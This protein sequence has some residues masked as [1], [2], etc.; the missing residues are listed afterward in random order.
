MRRGPHPV[1]F[2]RSGACC[3][4]VALACAGGCKSDLNHQLLERELRY[5]EDQIYRLQDELQAACA[6]LERTAGENASLKRQLGVHDGDS[7]A[8]RT[9]PVRPR[10]GAPAPVTVPPALEVPD[11]PAPPAAPLVPPTLEGVPPLPAGTPETPRTSALPPAGDDD[12]LELPAPPDP[13][14]VRRLSHEELAVDAGRVTHLVVNAAQ[15]SCLDTD[16]DGT[17][18]GLAVVFE[19]RDADERLVAVAGPV[20]IAVFDAA[21]GA[22]P[23]TGEAAPIARWDIAAEESLTRFRRTSRQRGLAF[24][25]PWPGRP[26]AGGHVRVAV[27]MSPPDAEPLEADATVAVR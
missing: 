2:A 15:T 26:P 11:T 23:S 4:L 20:S 27:R 19:P 13:G 16:G 5:Q 21:A 18:D 17:S 9:A 6:R 10:S 14:A 1:L 12:R 8:P 7:A 3:A 25:L 22:D 24:Q